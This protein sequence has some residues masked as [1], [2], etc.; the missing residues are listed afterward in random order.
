MPSSVFGP[1]DHR[2]EEE[3]REEM[4]EFTEQMSVDSCSD[5]REIPGIMG[6]SAI[7]VLG[8]WSATEPKVCSAAMRHTHSKAVQ[9]SWNLYSFIR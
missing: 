6:R 7:P 2:E 4:R 9:D 3:K 8:A 5:R 1:V